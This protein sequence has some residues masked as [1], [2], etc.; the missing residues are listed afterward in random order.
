MKLSETL[1]YDYTKK[2]LGFAYEKTGNSCEAEDL[3]Q[4]IMLQLID[5]IKSGREIEHISSFIYTVCCYTWSKYLRSNKRYWDYADIEEARYVA[6]IVNIEQ[7]AENNILGDS[8]RKAISQLAKIQRE[9]ILMHYYENKTTKEISRIL[10]IND[11]TIRLYLGNIR[12]DLKEKIT[13]SE[14]NLN[15]RPQSMI[16]GMDGWIEDVSNFRPLQSDLLVQNI[17]I[18]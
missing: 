9:I 2:I 17:A 1:L 4:E 18:V 16:V 12:R 3:A 15:M 11:S 10:G 14:Q 7:E 5:C 13:M 8:L 6:D